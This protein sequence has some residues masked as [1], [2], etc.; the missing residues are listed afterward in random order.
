MARAVPFKSLLVRPS[1]AREV[2]AAEEAEPGPVAA[3]RQGAGIHGDVTFRGQPAGSI[4]VALRRYRP[5]TAGETPVMTVTTNV[6]GQY[7]FDNVPTL[8]TGARYY[9]RF[10]NLVKDDSFLFAW[11]GQDIRL[12]T[13]GQSVRGGDFDIADLHLRTPQGGVSRAL[14]AS[15]GWQMRGL[16]ADR[17]RW[18]LRTQ[19]QTKSWI[20][21]DL[22][23]V[24]SFTLAELPEGVQ[25][26]TSYWWTAD[27]LGE[28][29]SFGLAFY[30]RSITFLPQTATPVASDTPSATHTP[31]GP[32]PTSTPRPLEEK[33]YL[34]Y[35][36]R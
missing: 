3:P 36:R 8:P 11:F 2:A 1:V 31:P 35:A 18:R 25:H 4:D 16:A 14:P 12:Y 30:L 19:D 20:T 27:V 15:F 32:T 6:D 29:D 34:P 9:V 22:G 7:L 23:A 17:Y 33:A 26:N 13:A 24:D 5:G 28:E 21:E 10:V